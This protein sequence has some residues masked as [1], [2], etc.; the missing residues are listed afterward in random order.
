MAVG[1][2]PASTREEE[3]T[4]PLVAGTSAGAGGA[5][6]AVA[7]VALGAVLLVAVLPPAAGGAP[8]SASEPVLD[9]VGSPGGLGDPDGEPHAASRTSQAASDRER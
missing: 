8:S 6:V 1:E 5:S 9:G 4:A 7:G 3:L 2:A